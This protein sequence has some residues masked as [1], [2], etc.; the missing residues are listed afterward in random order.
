MSGAMLGLVGGTSLSN[1]HPDLGA[2]EPA[3]FPGDG[4]FERIAD[5]ARFLLG[6]DAGIVALGDPSDGISPDGVGVSVAFA[7]AARSRG[8][9]A[10]SAQLADP[11]TALKL[12]FVSQASVPIRAGQERI[13]TLAVVTRDLRIFDARDVETLHRLADLVADNVTLHARGPLRLI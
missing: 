1:G 2:F 3:G 12:G 7:D 4:A 11:L 13:G 8:I 10:R 5:L 6:G 9:G